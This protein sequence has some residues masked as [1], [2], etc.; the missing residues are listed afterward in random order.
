MKPFM[1]TLLFLFHFLLPI[2]SNDIVNETSFVEMI[3]MEEIFGELYEDKGEVL[4]FISDEEIIHLRIQVYR[5]PLNQIT[6][7]S[8]RSFAEDK[9][10]GYTI[11]GKSESVYNGETTS[12]WLFGVWVK[13]ND[14]LITKVIYPRG[15]EVL[16]YTT[17]TEIHYFETHEPNVK[18]NLGWVESIYEPKIIK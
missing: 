11:V 7:K 3:E 14:V 4:K 10:F 1:I 12:T 15:K 18:V 6:Q 17:P 2:K 16:V 13:V 5:K 8:F 9:R